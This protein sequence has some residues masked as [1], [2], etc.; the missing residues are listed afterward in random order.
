MQN[1]QEKMNEVVNEEKKEM[2][3]IVT[4]A[5]REKSAPP[6]PVP[7]SSGTYEFLIHDWSKFL[8]LIVVYLYNNKIIRTS[9]SD[10]NKHHEL[11]SSSE[12]STAGTYN[13]IAIVA[14]LK[15]C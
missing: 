3:P 7:L 2:E 5:A 11:I 14:F 15:C 10:K 1:I 6:T 4:E 9:F 8:T 13:T 12:F